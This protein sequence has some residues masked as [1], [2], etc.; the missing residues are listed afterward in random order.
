MA[1][2]KTAVEEILAMSGADLGRRM[3][4]VLEDLRKLGIGQVLGHA[5]DFF[6]RLLRKLRSTDAAGIF[7]ASPK[8][9]DALMD[10]FWEGMAFRAAESPEMISLLQKVEREFH[11]NIEASDSPLA[12]HFVVRGGQIKGAHGLLPFKDEDFRFMG[13]TATL[14]ELLTGD[15]H[16]GFSNVNLQTAGHSGWVRRV[17]P[18]VRGI[19]RMVKGGVAEEEHGML[20]TKRNLNDL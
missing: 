19:N 11:V 15:L 2:A 7:N 12:S 4:E 14:C 5:P 17:A 6:S 20:C 16:L 10:L 1:D 3:P 18:V 13:P 9:G 8:S